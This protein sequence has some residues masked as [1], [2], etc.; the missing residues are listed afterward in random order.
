[1]VLPVDA[2][3]IAT[4]ILAASSL[5]DQ[6]GLMGHLMFVERIINDVLDAKDAQCTKLEE[7][8]LDKLPLLLEQNTCPPT[9]AAFIRCVAA[10][11]RL[12]GDWTSALCGRTIGVSMSILQASESRQPG[13]DLLDV[14]AANLVLALSVKTTQIVSSLMQ[15]GTFEDVRLL[16]IDA[17]TTEHQTFI[18]KLATDSE[19]S[20]ALRIRALEWLQ[21]HQLSAGDVDVLY[22]TAKQRRCVPLREAA[23]PVL[24]AAVVASGADAPNIT[25]ILKLIEA[26]TN[27]EEVSKV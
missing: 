25:K 12:T 5:K 13:S 23:L 2:C 20:D 4:P 8:L 22:A 21:L 15:A 3:S 18:A 1:M 7:S 6:N 26:A 9:R 10:Y 11:G 14:A 17:S 16:A 27:E 24:A 19:E